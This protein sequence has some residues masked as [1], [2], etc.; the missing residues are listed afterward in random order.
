[1]YQLGGL[2][3][4]M[5]MSAMKFLHAADIHLDSPLEGLSS[6]VQIPDDVT[7]HFTRRAFANLID[8]AITENVDFIILAGDLYDGDWRDYSTGLFFAQEMRR[9]NRPCYLI[10]GNHDARSQIT[11]NL[12][13][14]PN[15]WEFSSRKSETFRIDELRVALHGRSF[16]DR[17]V[18]ED[19]TESYS[20]PVEGYLNIGILHTSAEDP[21]GE[22]D[23]YA[24]CRVETLRSKG[25]DYWA[26]GHI[27]QRRD[28]NPAG[29]PWIVF[30]GNIQGRHA[31]EVGNKGCTMVDVRDGVIVGVAH[32]TL[33]VLRWASVV[34]DLDGAES[35]A[36]ISSRI[37]IEL[38]AA[39]L[40]A[41]GRP[42]I[43]RI[44]LTGAT[45]CHSILAADLAA[46]DAECRNAAA[47]VSGNLHVEKLR[48]RTRTPAYIAER[49]DALAALRLTFVEALAEADI[50]Q[51]LLDD[52]KALDGQIPVG[53]DRNRR[54][55]PTD[56]EELRAL[57]DDAWPR[58][59]RP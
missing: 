40:V 57:V 48:L 50:R 49:D 4:I 53:H 28:L 51:R 32:H 18:N 59:L 24:P 38:T 13:N 47:S 35:M 42:L 46:L 20:A 23:R 56:K 12:Q 8:L 6:N 37:R 27:H 55:A 17:A 52:F 54:R 7:H 2:K 15:V 14:P 22:H 43:A 33:D 26:L 31:R 5:Y 41:D 16:P 10:R 58:G 34:T 39:E 9:L 25:Y 36:E 1:M 29:H 21:A 11:R 3:V 44:T 45:L 30:P 19:L